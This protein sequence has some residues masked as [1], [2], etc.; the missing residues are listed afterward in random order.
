MSL[1]HEG[2]FAE[3]LSWGLKAHVED[4]TDT[5]TN[6]Y[7]VQ[8]FIWVGEYAEARRIS[9]VLDYMVDVAEGR[10]NEAIQ[11]TQRKM[12]LDPEN[13]AVIAAAA[14]VLYD[15]GRID[16]ALP[17][18]ERLRD[19]RP[20]GRPI[21]GFNDTMM[22]LALARRNAGNEDGAQAAA[23]IA[24]KDHA[25]LNAAGEKSQFQH[26]TEAMIAAFENNPDRVIAALKSA[27]QL[28]LRNP[29]VF[30]DPM[31]EELWAEPRFVALQQELDAILG[32]EH[33]KVLQ[34]LCFNNPAPGG[35]QPMPVTCEGVE[36]QLVL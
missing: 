16:E 13:E 23:Q 3:G 8:G 27:M 28:G 34:L 20:E 9:D 32:A 24:K 26:R 29:Q 35:W 36:E 10:F 7:V 19:F 12:Q 6:F 22:R 18:Y 30:G 2:R 14:F 33:D 5:F 25:A 4:P 31:F 17:L 15:A 11:A 21:T 1:I